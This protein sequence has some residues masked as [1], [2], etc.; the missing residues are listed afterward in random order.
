VKYEGT[1]GEAKLGK[2]ALTAR[3]GFSKNTFGYGGVS[4][5]TGDLKDYLSQKT[6]FQLG[7]R[8]AF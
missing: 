5:A 7:L 1:G 6:V 4:M 2:A 8:M 3:Y